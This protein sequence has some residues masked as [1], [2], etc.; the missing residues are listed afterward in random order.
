[1]YPTF[2]YDILISFPIEIPQ[3]LIHKVFKY[4]PELYKLSCIK[5]RIYKSMI[6]C[7]KDSILQNLIVQTCSVLEYEYDQLMNINMI[8]ITHEY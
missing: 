6:H 3:L 5:K 1:M 7:N 2:Y 8:N 4:L